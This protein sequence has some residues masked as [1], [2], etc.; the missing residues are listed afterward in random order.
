MR[1]NILRKDTET[2]QCRAD[3]FYKDSLD[4]FVN[5]RIIFMRKLPLCLEYLRNY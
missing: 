5:K 1:K 4:T 3:R 2:F